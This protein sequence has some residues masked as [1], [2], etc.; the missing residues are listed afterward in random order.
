MNIPTN[1]K[2]QHSVR[3]N[4]TIHWYRNDIS[5]FNYINLSV[6]RASGSVVIFLGLF[7]VFVSQ[8]RRTLMTFLFGQWGHSAVWTILTAPS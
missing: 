4:L 3:R 2:F 8:F 1:R 5:I 7:D 6:H